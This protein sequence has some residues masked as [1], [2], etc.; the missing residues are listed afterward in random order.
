MNGQD[1]RDRSGK[2]RRRTEYLAP[3]GDGLNH[4]EL[5][6]SMGM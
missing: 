4:P 3:V 1:S 2:A 5:A 6:N